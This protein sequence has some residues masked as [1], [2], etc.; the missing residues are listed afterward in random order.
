MKYLA[1]C[2]VLVLFLAISA[3]SEEKVIHKYKVGFSTGLSYPN[4]VLSYPIFIGL[5]HSVFFDTRLGKYSLLYS[6]INYSSYEPDEIDLN[7]NF[8]PGNFHVYNSK[9]SKPYKLYSLIVGYGLTSSSTGRVPAIRVG[10]GLF[11]DYSREDE[12]N[13]TYLNVSNE[14]VKKNI[15][16]KNKLSA[17]LNLRVGLDIPIYRDIAG[18]CADLDFN[19]KLIGPTSLSSTQHPQGVSLTIGLFGRF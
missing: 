5:K 19:P 13:V 4:N 16:A 8:Q 18:L 3:H 12:I 10:V 11:L 15:N 6:T 14:I 2:F 9:D 7:S 1:L 17:G